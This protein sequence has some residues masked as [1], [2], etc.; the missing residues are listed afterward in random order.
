VTSPRR[1]GAA[2]PAELPSGAGLLF[3][4]LRLVDS[5]ARP[6][7]EA[8]TRRYGIGLSEWRT[9]AVVN[10]RPGSSAS[11]IAARSGLDKMSVSR[12]LASLERDGRLVRRP[13]PRDARRALASP[14][15]SGRR[16]HASLEARAR[17]LEAVAT[18]PLGAA[19]ARRLRALVTRSTR[20]AEPA[21][22]AADEPVSG[23]RTGRSAPRAPR[24]TTPAG[25]PSGPVPP[26][27]RAAARRTDRRG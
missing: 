11:E 8:L 23:T 7:Q 6:F 12:A 27:S 24:A 1:P 17:E 15:A 13:D 26:P 3:G 20:A 21:A 14:T 19:D 16:L 22:A 18:R 10:A 2:G 5:L 4:L 25:R 9:L